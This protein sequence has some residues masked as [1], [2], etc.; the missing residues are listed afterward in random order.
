VAIREHNV[1]TLEK[2]FEE[3]MDRLASKGIDK[4]LIV[5]QA[6]I[7]PAC[8]TGSMELP[9]AEKVFEM[10]KQLSARMKEKYKV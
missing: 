10:L 2:K 7:T 4:E 1:D 6:V 3:E 8:G 9:D 5:S